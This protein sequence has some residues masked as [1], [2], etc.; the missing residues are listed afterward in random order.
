MKLFNA[1]V[2]RR[3]AN[4]ARLNAANEFNDMGKTAEANVAYGKA[5]IASDVTDKQKI[6]ALGG[7]AVTFKSMGMA[8][9]ARE[10]VQRILAINPKNG[11]ALKLEAEFK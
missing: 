3:A 5:L 2:P 9:Q 4:D 6:L 11:F 10:S 8:D 7:L 1:G